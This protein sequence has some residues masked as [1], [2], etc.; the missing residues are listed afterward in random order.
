MPGTPEARA[1]LMVTSI[2][3]AVANSNVATTSARIADVKS[4]VIRP[5]PFVA[6]D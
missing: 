4:P 1:R 2:T 3:V 5:L 6:C